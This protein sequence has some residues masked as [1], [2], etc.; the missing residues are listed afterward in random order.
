MTD[1]LSQG[2]SWLEDQRHQHLTRMVTYQRG[3]SEVEL[4][5]TIGRTVFEQDDH[6]GGLT[7]I[8]SRDFLIRAV[9]LVL[10]AETT[11]PQP[12]DRIIETDAVATYT[13]EVMAPG[14]EPPW[15]YSDVNRLT[16][17]IHTK[18]V[19]TEVL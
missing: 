18:H 4:P 3:G 6:V 9:D 12:G 15:R 1:L 14:S 2:L 13:Y 5:A 11:L 8:E 7:R 16:L 10:A 19:A 17:R